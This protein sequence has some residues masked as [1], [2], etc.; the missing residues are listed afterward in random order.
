M[1]LLGVKKAPFGAVDGFKSAVTRLPSISAKC[2][3]LDWSESRANPS[4]MAFA[5]RSFQYKLCD[6]KVKRNEVK[7]AFQNFPVPPPIC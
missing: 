1:E 4:D 5:Y 7:S 3:S 6:L 2:T